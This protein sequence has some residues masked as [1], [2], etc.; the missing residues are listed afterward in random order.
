MASGEEDDG[1]DIDEIPPVSIGKTRRVR[2]QP[3][4]VRDRAAELEDKNVAVR[5]A[6]LSMTGLLEST[7]LLLLVHKHMPMDFLPL[8]SDG[9]SKQE[10]NIKHEVKICQYLLKR[11]S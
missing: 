1:S 6:K 10:D 4:S 9:L 7:R 8:L 5:E 3:K 11:R 2:K